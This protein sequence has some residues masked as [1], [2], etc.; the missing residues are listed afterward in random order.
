MNTTSDITS[1]SDAAAASG[2][3]R[4]GSMP[5]SAVL[6]VLES[7]D[8]L[9]RQEFHRRYCA[10]PD[11]KKAELVEGVVYVGSPVRVD[12]HGTPHADVIGW[13]YAYA[14]AQPGLQVADNATVLLDA[15]NEVQPDAFL[16]FHPWTG[17]GARVQ[18]SYIHGAPLLVV[19]VAASSAS[20]DLHE[21]LRAYRR[22]GVQEYIVWRTLDGQIDW[23]LLQDG[24]YVRQQPDE[25]GLIESRNFPGLRL[26]VAA[27]LRGD[28]AA[29][30]AALRAGEGA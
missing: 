10:R 5:A 21:K 22:N 29:V 2:A 9:T 7:G 12:V 20:Y 15:D 17:A 16:Y 6:P 25:R 4:G 27:M 23:L 1:T 3:N 24:A 11:I 28:R 13:L 14:A 8:H 26:D 19:E 30:L 18:D